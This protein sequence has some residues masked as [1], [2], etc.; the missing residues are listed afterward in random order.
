MVKRLL[1]VLFFLV[2]VT[3]IP[4]G[5]G[6]DDVKPGMTEVRS[7]EILGQPSAV[8]TDREQIN[9]YLIGD[10]KCAVSA[11]KALV[12]DRLWPR[13]DVIVGVNGTG[14]GVCRLFA[15]LL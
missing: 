9:G 6:A 14:D 2:A 8:V 1:F 10:E 12:Y 7:R 3:A 11:A 13:S 5:D 4:C 15:E